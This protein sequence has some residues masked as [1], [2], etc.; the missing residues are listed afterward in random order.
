M[1]AAGVTFTTPPRDETY[2]RVAVFLHCEGNK[3]D[4][5]GPTQSMTAPTRPDARV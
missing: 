3:W 1:L 4:L 5:L 2:G